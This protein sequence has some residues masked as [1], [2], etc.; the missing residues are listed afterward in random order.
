MTMTAAPG[1]LHAAPLSDEQRL[2]YEQD[3][4]LIVRNFF[5]LDR[6]TA[7]SAEADA[8]LR[9]TELIHTDNLRCRWTTDT[10]NQAC[11]FETFDPVADLAPVC[12][13]LAV[14]PRLLAAVGVLYG[15]EACLFKDKLIF[16]S[17][18]AKGYNLHQDYISWPSFP[19]TFMTAIVPIDPSTESN[20]CTEVFAGYHHNGNLSADD[21][22]YHELSTGSVDPS[23]GVKLELEAGDVAFFGGFTPHRSAPNLSDGYRRQLYL[24][25]N[26]ISD[27]GH[28]RDRHYKEFHE[29]LRKKYAEYGRAE[30]YFR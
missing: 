11:V 9:R 25:Y 16:K 29:W 22:E 27:G 10:R 26:A 14:D 23:R 18:G 21:G 2:Q 1:R 12:G 30:T 24:S 13:K 6:I 8:L 5:S 20:G 15:E 7:A 4:F 3:G 19:K 17:P 28:Q